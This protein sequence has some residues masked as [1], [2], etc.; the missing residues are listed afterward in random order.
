MTILG[1][2]TA[3]LYTCL[4]YSIHGPWYIDYASGKSLDMHVSILHGM[5]H[6]EFRFAYSYAYVGVELKC[7]NSPISLHCMRANVPRILAT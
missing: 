3:T 1:G 6:P 7:M 4:M 5:P 2:V